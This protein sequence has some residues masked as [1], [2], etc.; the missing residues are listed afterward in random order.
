MK[1]NFSAFFTLLFSL[2]FFLIVPGVT[3]QGVFTSIIDSDAIPAFLA[4]VDP[5][6]VTIF[7]NETGQSGIV[8]TLI[9]DRRSSDVDRKIGTINIS[10]GTEGNNVNVSNIVAQVDNDTRKSLI[11]GAN[12]GRIGK[13]V[14]F[15]V[16]TNPSDNTV[17]VCIGVQNLANIFSGCLAKGGVTNEYKLHIGGD[18]GDFT[19]TS[20]VFNNE[21]ILKI[22]GDF[23][24]T[25]VQSAFIEYGG[26]DLD[27]IDV[28]ETLDLDDAASQ[29]Y[30]SREEVEHFVMV[31]GVKYLF[32]VDYVDP[33]NKYATIFIENLNKTI[34][35]LEGDVEEFDLNF[36]GDYDAV[37]TLKKIDYPEVYLDIK[38]YVE[39]VKLEFAAREKVAREKPG[40]FGKGGGIWGTF[41]K[42]GQAF[43]E[44][45]FKWMILLTVV[46]IIF[47]VI[48]GKV[49]NKI[50]KAT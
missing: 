20:E 11:H 28:G 14:N 49:L 12:S 33:D 7:F 35:L 43:R 50:W 17:F 38:T 47:F 4:F 44:H 34:T 48:G 19:V 16:P 31:G 36:D 8:S 45:M 15:F 3:A 21:N 10:F 2:C 13:I 32:V 42:M 22:V 25:G 1:I 9:L 26:G 27:T 23:S 18:T 6:D 30:I 37:L 40:F 5:D 41:L 39:A 29:D 46:V 24:G